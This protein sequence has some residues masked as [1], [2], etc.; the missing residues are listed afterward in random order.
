MNDKLCRFLNTRGIPQRYLNL[1]KQK[2]IKKDFGML[3]DLEK[4][5]NALSEGKNIVLTGGVGRGKSFLAYELAYEIIKAFDYFYSDTEPETLARW[6]EKGI[7]L[8]REKSVFCSRASLIVS[9]YKANFSNLQNSLKKT[10]MS[11]S[12]YFDNPCIKNS[13][14]IIDEIDDLRADDYMLLNEIVVS[15]Y[16]NEIPL[17][18]ISNMN[19]VD[20]LENF[21]E[22]AASRLS[23]NSL[24]LQSTGEDLRNVKK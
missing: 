17:C 22:K 2:A 13:L 18:L 21:S 3:K 16:E 15:A 24:F 14:V 4:G 8:H 23:E 19:V 1:K 9:D 10:L 12:V 6:R 5:L 20:F 7:R 11:E